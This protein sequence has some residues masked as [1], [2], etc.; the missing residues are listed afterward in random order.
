MCCLYSK[1]ETRRNKFS[2]LQKQTYLGSEKILELSS[3]LEG[4]NQ[5]FL[6]ELV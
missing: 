6:T 4:P 1:F 3:Q 5:E 2:M